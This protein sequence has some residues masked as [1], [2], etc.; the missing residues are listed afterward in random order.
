MEKTVNALVEQ[1]KKVNEE[2]EKLKFRLSNVMLSL[3]SE[4][5]IF[6]WAVKKSESFERNLLAR[7]CF[8]EGAEYMRKCVEQGNGT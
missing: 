4:E 8:I 1:L 2:N 6:Q 3:P 5:D 7:Q